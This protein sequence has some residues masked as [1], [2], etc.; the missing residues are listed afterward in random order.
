MIVVDTKGAEYAASG[1][2]R[3]YLA[4]YEGKAL[5]FRGESQAE[6]APKMRRTPPCNGSAGQNAEF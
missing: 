2:V 1:F 4:E 5:A 6:N 3:L